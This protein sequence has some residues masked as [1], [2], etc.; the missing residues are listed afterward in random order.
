M[1][2]YILNELDFLNNSFD[3]V[4]II[5]YNESDFNPEKNRI[6]PGK[7]PNIEVIN[8]LDLPKYN[9]LNRLTRSYEIIKL[10]LLEIF[11][12]D[13]TLK[14]IQ[15][16]KS[17][18]NRLKHYH[19]ISK[20]LKQ[21][22]HEELVSEISE[23]FCYHYWNHDGVLIDYF[24]N[25]S[26]NINI[27]KSFSRAH[28]IDLFHSSWPKG[29]LGF[30]KLKIKYLTNI[31]PI[32]NVGL[33]Y[34]SRKFP[35]YSSKFKV[36]HLGIPDKSNKNRNFPHTRCII[37]SVSNIAEIKRLHLMVDVMKYLPQDLFQWVHIGDGSSEFSI[38]LKQFAKISGINFE[39]LGQLNAQ[40]INDFYNS[41][42]I[43][44]AMNLSYMEGVS[45]SIMESLMHGV[46]CI[47]TNV[48]GSSDLIQT[49]INGYLID[50]NFNP[51]SIAELIISLS[52]NKDKWETFRDKSREV[53]EMK[54]NSTINYQ[55]FY[56]DILTD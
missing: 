39:F 25:K 28:S 13:D 11:N 40:E 27:K 35:K 34:L 24:L 32:S 14:T 56:C 8:L 43:L 30:E 9:I 55:L 7:Y 31:Y 21:F 46:P 37:L 26:F 19:A 1:E 48:G 49:N 42:D 12:C 5:P 44:C 16:S 54:F 23:I 53:F 10:I 3:S 38:P 17:L 52:E 45:V 29:Y 47:V 51:Q 20:K 18:F 33:D 15:K 2:S 50:S 22:I 41:T 6:S 36:A 4:Y